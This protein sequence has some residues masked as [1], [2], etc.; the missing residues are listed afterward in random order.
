M[1]GLPRAAL[2]KN[3]QM[4]AS[5]DSTLG[6]KP[7]VSITSWA[8]VG[9][10]V[11]V[12]RMAVGWEHFRLAKLPFLRTRSSH[13]VGLNRAPN[14]FKMKCSLLLLSICNCARQVG[15]F[16]LCV[17]RETGNLL[18]PSLSSLASDEHPTNVASPHWVQ[19]FGLPL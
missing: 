4:P 6:G 14:L 15:R 10:Y 19:R 7:H 2:S 17:K 3:D 11:L 1:R 8:F 9:I 13:D 5:E 12:R 18:E 16:L